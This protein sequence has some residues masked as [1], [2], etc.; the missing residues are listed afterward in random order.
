M[1]A[2]TT[3]MP[4]PHTTIN[5]KTTQWPPPE[6]CT[7]LAAASTTARLRQ[8]N[9][10]RRLF[11][12]NRDC[13]R[14]FL[15]PPASTA[16]APALG[17]RALVTGVIRAWRGPQP[18][19]SQALRL[20]GTTEAPDQS[21]LHQWDPLEI[22]RQVVLG[23]WPKEGPDRLRASSGPTL[24]AAATGWLIIGMRAQ[25]VDATP[26]PRRTT[27][28][29]APSWPGPAGCLAANSLL[30]L[31]LEPSGQSEPAA[32]PQIRDGLILNWGMVSKPPAITA[33]GLLTAA[34]AG[35]IPWAKPSGQTTR[36]WTSNV[37]PSEAW[38][39]AKIEQ[40]CSAVAQPDLGGD[41]GSYAGGGAKDGSG[42]GLSSTSTIAWRSACRI[43]AAKR[44]ASS[45]PILWDLCL[46]AL[47]TLP[48]GSQHGPAPVPWWP[49]GPPRRPR[50]W[51]LWLVASADHQRYLRGNAQLL[52]GGLPMIAPSTER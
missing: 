3:T 9:R 5:P 27:T 40:S 45:V 12:V 41:A 47:A 36:S 13:L 24:E 17:P 25:E 42:V 32:F 14:A 52:A 43:W 7:L 2:S 10:L 44:V 8:P 19:P 1:S 22:H 23:A 11:L 46:R 35:S 18:T 16:S 39:A 30:G 48:A 51:R 50:N 26:I 49:F 34:A 38:S 6:R 21:G 28:Q 20:A 37:R 31:R 33:S 15:A 4:G 29:S